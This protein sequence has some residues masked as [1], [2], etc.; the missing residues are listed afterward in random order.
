MR[1]RTGRRGG[2]ASGRCSRAPNS[3]RPPAWSA[4][5]PARRSPIPA[6][7]PSSGVTPSLVT[8]STNVP[9][10][11]LACARRPASRGRACGRCGSPPRAP[12][13]RAARAPPAPS[14]ARAVELDPEIGVLVAQARDLLGE[15]RLGRGGGAAERPLHRRAQVAERRL[16]LLGAAPARLLVKRLVAGERER[17]AEEALHDALV[18]L[19][20]E[21]DALLERD[22]ALVLAGRGARHRRERRHLAE[23]PE[24]LALGRGERRSLAAAVAEDRAHPA[25]ARRHR[26]D[27]RPCAPRAARRS[28][29]EACRSRSSALSSTRSCSSASRASAARLQREEVAGEQREVDAEAARR[30]GSAAAS[31]S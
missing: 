24:H 11:G 10:R 18:D 6:G 15:R 5:K 1:P 2:P 30:R 21:V 17:D 13:G 3:S 4:S 29:R 9:S 28:R 7:P 31:E 20:R 19:A 14:I 22:R 12:T 27:R 16:H 23:D 26:R 25:S 8:S